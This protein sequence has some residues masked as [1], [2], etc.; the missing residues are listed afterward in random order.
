MIVSVVTLD[1]KC[2]SDVEIHNSYSKFLLH[3]INS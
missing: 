3:E 1:A 2:I